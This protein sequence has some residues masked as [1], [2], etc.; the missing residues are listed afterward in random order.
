MLYLIVLLQASYGILIGIVKGLGL[1]YK[2]SL[3]STIN[4]GIGIVLAILI[5]SPTIFSQLRLG[6]GPKLFDAV[7]GPIGYNMGFVLGLLTLNTCLIY[8]LG[9]SKWQNI[10]KKMT[11]FHDQVHEMSFRKHLFH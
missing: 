7:H 11:A 10:A 4:Y 2:A 3:I 6:H 1:Q 5:G 8:L 9:S